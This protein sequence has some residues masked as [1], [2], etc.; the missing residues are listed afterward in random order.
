MQLHPHFRL[1]MIPMSLTASLE[2][3][4]GTKS[5]SLFHTFCC[6]SQM[7]KAYAGK[8]ACSILQKR[9]E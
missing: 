5:E 2:E 6:H 4:R 9:R 7:Y 3:S 1:A 8:G